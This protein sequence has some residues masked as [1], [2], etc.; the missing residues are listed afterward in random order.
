MEAAMRNL[1]EQQDAL[2]D[3]REAGIHAK[4]QLGGIRAASSHPHHI[5]SNPAQQQSQTFIPSRAHPIPPQGEDFQSARMLWLL[6][7]RLDALEGAKQSNFD[8]ASLCLVPNIVIPPKFKLPT[9]DKYGWT[10]C[11]KSHLT[12][13]CKKM[14]P[15]AHDDALLIHFFQQCLTGMALGW[16]LGLKRERVLT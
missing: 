10:T 6:E 2:S 7:E 11:P 15:H 13:Y 9:F 5:A 3:N 1:E 14:A 16:Y 4:S 12:M 8:V